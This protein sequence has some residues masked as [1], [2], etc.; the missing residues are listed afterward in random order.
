[1]K[2]LHSYWAHGGGAIAVGILLMLVLHREE[3]SG[4]DMLLWMH[5]ALLMLHQFEEYVY[6]GGF[7]EFYNCNIW[8]KS[9]LTTRPLTNNGILFVNVVLGWTAYGIAALI[10]KSA[11]WLATGLLFPTMVNGVMHSLMAILLRRYNPGLF[12]ALVLFLPFSSF[13]LGYVL[14][15]LTLREWLLAGTS[16]AI[17]SAAIPVTVWLSGKGKET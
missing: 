1:M 16:G 4:I 8:N 5:I 6:P 3:W 17:S 7:Q 12:T 11:L 15:Y 14:E 2:Y 13:A 10:G 9:R